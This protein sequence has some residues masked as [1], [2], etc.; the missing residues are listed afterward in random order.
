MR[1]VSARGCLQRA[2]LHGGAPPAWLLP[3]SGSVLHEQPAERPAVPEPRAHVLAAAP[4]VLRRGGLWA[5]LHFMLD[6]NET[7]ARGV[8]MEVAAQGCMT[9]KEEHCS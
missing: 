5:R 7:G 2:G 4:G 1:L 6:G 8:L 3:A 9:A